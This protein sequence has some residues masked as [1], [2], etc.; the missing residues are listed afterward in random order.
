MSALVSL[1]NLRDNAGRILTG[2][3]PGRFQ[4]GLQDGVATDLRHHVVF[5]L[6]QGRAVGGRNGAWC[7]PNLKSCWSAIKWLED[8]RPGPAVGK[9]PFGA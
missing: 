3:V 7:C 6:V 1:D 4:R 2:D 9:D 8:V 5:V